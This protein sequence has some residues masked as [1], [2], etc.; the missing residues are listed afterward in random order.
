MSLTIIKPFDCVVSH[1]HCRDSLHSVYGCY[2]KV[3][4]VT[5]ELLKPEILSYKTFELML[6][7]KNERFRGVNMPIHV[8]DGGKTS[9]IY[10]IRQSIAK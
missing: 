9:Q 4:G 1:F 2:I 8:N 7:A 5:I 6:L 10:V 3:S